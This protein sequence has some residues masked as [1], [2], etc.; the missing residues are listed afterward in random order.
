MIGAIGEYCL[1]NK[2]GSGG[3]GAVFRAYDPYN[4]RAVAL[5]VLKPSADEEDKK[6]FRREG[7]IL[8]AI[9]HKNVISLLDVRRDDM[10]LLDGDT[11]YVFSDV[12]YVVMELMPLS[13]K[14][15][16]EASGKLSQIRSL[17]LCAQVAHGLRAVHDSG[18][19]HRDIKPQN[20][21]LDWDGN[22][23]VADF[24][25]ARTEGSDLT[26]S[27]VFGFGSGRY[28]SH[29]QF[30]DP[31][32]VDERADIYSLGVT[33]YEMLTGKQYKPGASTKASRPAI[34]DALERIV[35]KCVAPYPEQR[36]QTMLE[37]FRAIVL[38]KDA[39][40]RCTLGDLYEA[41]GG[42]NWR[43]NDN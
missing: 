35:K 29:E 32:R 39:I 18:V 31:K 12:P 6:R 20:I 26:K 42:P 25:I 33:L 21:L 15:A 17:I 30:V 27:E 3:F 41:T 7:L 8:A 19:V 40:A 5:K 16:M 36:Y 14:D 13:L 2:I 1:M 11:P 43:M 22:A 4:S 23:V 34:P 37:L 9:D 38:D 10:R 28:M 24:G